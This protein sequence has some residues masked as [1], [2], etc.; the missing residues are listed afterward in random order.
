M[1]SLSVYELLWTAMMATVLW[2]CVKMVRGHDAT[3]RALLNLPAPFDS[4]SLEPSENP[5]PFL[6]AAGVSGNSLYSWWRATYPQ[7]Q[8]A[9]LRVQRSRGPGGAH[10]F[11]K[12][13]LLLPPAFDQPDP[14]ALLT[15]AHELAHVA[16]D[17]TAPT[18]RHRLILSSSLM[19]V[20]ALAT[21]TGL[22]LHQT[23]WTQYPLGAFTIAAIFLDRL[24]VQMEYGATAAAP[25]LIRHWIPHSGLSPSGQQA[26]LR[27][28]EAET[29]RKLI[30]YPLTLPGQNTFILMY[31]L[32]A[33][34]TIAL[35]PSV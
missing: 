25:A 26:L 31:I 16:Q 35:F 27:F 20:S 23:Q 15:T 10:C 3:S 18:L 19:L 32:F 9:S 28:C 22:V 11:F 33:I 30:D 29:T 14:H 17:A 2:L 6:E 8:P 1:T 12:H 34:A 7:L 21:I 13:T 4:P 24:H 5:A